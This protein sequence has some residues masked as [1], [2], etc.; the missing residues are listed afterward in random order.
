M[1]RVDIVRRADGKVVFDPSPLRPVIGD[2]IFWCN[3][4]PQA[5]HWIT[6]KGKPNDFWFGFPLAPFTGEPP[7]R[8]GEIVFQA[9]STDDMVYVCSLHGGEEGVITFS[10]AIVSTDGS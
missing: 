9:P 8:T 1:A 10:S 4:D 6:L 5:Q 2:G 7:D 3:R